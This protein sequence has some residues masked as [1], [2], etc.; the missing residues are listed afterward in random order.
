MRLK[1]YFSLSDFLIF[2]LKHLIRLY[3]FLIA[4]LLGPRCRFNPSCSNYALEALSLYGLL[5]GTFLILKRLL[6]CHPW[7]KYDDDFLPLKKTSFS[8]KQYNL[9][10]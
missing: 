3:Q 9:N 6:R 4:P 2:F 8:S 7:G 1:K 10:P 5:T